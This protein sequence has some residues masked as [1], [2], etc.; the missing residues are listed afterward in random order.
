[1]KILKTITLL[2]AGITLAIIGVCLGITIEKK[3]VE[4]LAQATHKVTTVAVINLDE[5]VVVDGNY[6]YY[7]GE[8]LKLPSA[9]Y[10]ITSYDDAINGVKE[11]RYGAYAIVPATFSES[12][13]SLN[14]TPIEAY[15]QYEY[16]PELSDE[17]KLIVQQ[18]IAAL[19]D[20]LMDNVSYVY[21]ANVMAN[22]HQAQDDAKG[23]LA[24]DIKDMDN[25][26]AI[27]AD[28]LAVSLEYRDLDIVTYD[29]SSVDLSSYISDNSTN[30]G[31]I[32]GVYDSAKKKSDEQVAGFKEG[33][34][35][36]GNDITNY[37]THINGVDIL[38]NGDGSLI[39]QDELNEVRDKLYVTEEARTQ[40][41][42][43]IQHDIKKQMYQ[44]EL[45]YQ[46]YLNS[47][48]A[49]FN[50]NTNAEIALWYGGV[51]NN[52]NQYVQQQLDAYI[53]EEV[54]KAKMNP[55]YSYTEG[56]KSINIT[57]DSVYTTG[58]AGSIDL[59]QARNSYSG[60]P[61]DESNAAVLAAVESMELSTGIVSGI[62]AYKIA[63]D[64]VI[65]IIDEKIISAYMNEMKTESEAIVQDAKNIESDFNAVLK[66]LSAYD[67]SKNVDTAALNNI[68][69]NINN[70]NSTIAS[71][72][73]QNI[74]ANN[75]Y[76][77]DLQTTTNNNIALL[78]QDMADANAATIL[79]VE[80]AVD[81]LKT[82]RGDLNEKNVEL[83]TEFTE[84]MPYSRIGELENQRMYSYIINPVIFNNTPTIDKIT[85][86]YKQDER[87]TMLYACIGSSIVMLGLII[88]MSIKARK[89]KLVE[90]KSINHK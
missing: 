84:L 29:I 39:V 57:W 80:N 49:T 87:I 61:C 88:A 9:D 53:A 52:V 3:N 23:V 60:I 28:E 1:M 44:S 26:T 69:T 14:G 55:A 58:G 36:I 38:H 34:K 77:Y 4:E 81:E 35:G 8:L 16:D 75:Q 33:L 64:E 89:E 22:F 32:Q 56:D 63:P 24:N 18:N 25:I 65:T 45:G 41:K 40:A 48:I 83:L 72:M 90:I 37:E 17:A 85:P 13:E 20:S 82:N 66:D 12:V 15:I 50:Q 46:A 11:G 2:L 21:V 70:N 43:D 74:S 7:S 10:V 6:K 47:N 19:E 31:N 5:G 76:I 27:D 68:L 79:N 78:R 59:S 42:T 30:I 54:N 62:E 71:E 73:N 51:Q 86:I 67:P